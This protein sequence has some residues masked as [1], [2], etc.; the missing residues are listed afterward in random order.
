L[1]VETENGPVDLLAIGMASRSPRGFSLVGEPLPDL[2]DGFAAGELLLISEPYAY[3]QGLK[4]GDPLQLYSAGGPRKFRVG[5]VFRDF[6]SDR[7]LLVMAGDVF[8]RYW[9]DPGISAIGLFLEPGTDLAQ[10]RD[11]VR[12]ALADL[13]QGARVRSNREIRAHSLEIFDRT[14]TVTR[15]LRL[16]AV[17]VAFVGI[18]SALMAMLL[19]QERERAILRASGVTRGQLLGLVGLQTGL[20]G[21]MAG[22]L[23]LPLGLA[24]GRMLIQ[25]INLR[26]FGWSLQPL[27]PPGV[28][29][30]AVLLAL[31]AALLAGLLPAWRSTRIQ[32]ASALREE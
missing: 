32:P 10:V 31:A 12:A 15:V 20:M 19:E 28:F 26:S 7:G 24:M 8:A 5:A 3:H 4:A 2:W 25:V 30:D 23:A 18:F 11:R 29:A 14:F 6:G 1:E 16:L 21:L 22:L 27:M 17:L 9:Q 13:P